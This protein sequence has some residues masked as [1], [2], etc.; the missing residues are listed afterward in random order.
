MCVGER[1]REK[2]RKWT[3][4]KTFGSHTVCAAVFPMGKEMK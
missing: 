2:M 1:T 4:M 3:G